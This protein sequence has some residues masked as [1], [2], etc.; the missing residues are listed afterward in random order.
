[1]DYINQ[2][3]HKIVEKWTQL[4]EKARPVVTKISE[5]L[6]VVSDKV[7]GIWKQVV[8]LKKVILAVPVGVAAVILAIGNMAKLPARVGL[9]LQVNGSFSVEIARELAVLGPI[10]VT[11][12]CLLLM[13]ASK[14]VL[15]PWFASLVSLALPVIILLIN[16]FPS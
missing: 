1:M 7:G 8:K 4:R 12:V 13:F 3:I 11:A 6:S 9:D 15:T 10:A 14:R 5:K 2:F 16:T